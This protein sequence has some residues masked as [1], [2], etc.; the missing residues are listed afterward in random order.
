MS[1]GSKPDHDRFESKSRF[2]LRIFPSNY[3]LFFV[4]IAGLLVLTMSLLY[5]FQ[6]KLLHHPD[7]YDLAEVDR[8]AAHW[9]LRVWPDGETSAY[10]G[11]IATVAT[12]G[13]KGTIVVFHG[14]AWS[15][16]DRTY[17]SE[18]LGPFGFR[19][20]LLEYPGYGARQ[21]NWREADLI[22]DGAESL[23]LVVR[24]FGRPVYVL[25]ES[26]GAGVAAGAI[27]ESRSPIDGALLFTPWDSLPNVAQ[28]VFWFFLVR[29]LVKDQYDSVT[30]LAA[31]P[32][33]VG[34][35]LADQ[36]EIVPRKATMHLYET[37]QGPK[38]LWR[39][40]GGHNSWIESTD[41]K[42]WRELVE[43]MTEVKR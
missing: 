40:S 38:R 12:G 41:Q 11:F 20:V 8:R 18:V 1:E 39:V 14:N 32:G 25:G 3:K 10:R 28:A 26:L 2:R 6:D 13:G 21:G 33:P 15:A 36:D 22:A 31:F 4:R 37:Y 19:V 9:G 5:A 24:E 34:I 43:F 27:R 7:R 29:R 17:F 23:K 16:V 35:V 30:A 42:W